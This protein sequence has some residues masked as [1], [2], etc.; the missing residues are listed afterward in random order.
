MSPPR[1]TTNSKPITKRIIIAGMAAL[2]GRMIATGIKTL[3]VDE[4]GRPTASLWTLAAAQGSEISL[5]QFERG[6]G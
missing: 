2:T 6:S 4:K 5:R 3:P 1:K